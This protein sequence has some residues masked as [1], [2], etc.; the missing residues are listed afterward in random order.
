MRG[1]RAGNGNARGIAPLPQRVRARHA[2]GHPYA[3]VASTF[4]SELEAGRAP[5]VFEDGGQRRDFVHV[6]DV[7]R[8]NVLALTAEPAPTGAFNIASGEV[9]TVGDLAGALSDRISGSAL[10]PVVTGRWRLG[11]VRHITASPARAREVLGFEAAVSFSG[12]MA[13]LA[14]APDV[15]APTG[16]RRAVPT[17]APA[18]GR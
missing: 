15:A 17:P 1:V 6:S 10:A 12:G 14:G 2:E 7:A 18:D 9:H 3:G 13:E 16:R 8:A 4:R 5:T 11:D